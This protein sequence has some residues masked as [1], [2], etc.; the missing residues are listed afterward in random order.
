LWIVSKKVVYEPLVSNELFE[1]VQQQ[2]AAG[3]QRH[4]SA[5][6]VRVQEHYLLRDLR[7]RTQA[8]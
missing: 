4:P 2:L 6:S 5:Q 7:R 3:A 8:H 1:P